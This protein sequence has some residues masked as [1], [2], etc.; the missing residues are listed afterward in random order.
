MGIR[1]QSLGELLQKLEANEYIRRYPAPD[2][3]RALIVELTAKGETFQLQKPEYD[4]LF[5]ELSARERRELQASLDKISEQL[6]VLIDKE[7]E[8]RPVDAY[9]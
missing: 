1:P 2:D 4:E 6:K 3:R 9:Y 5:I 7:I 8:E